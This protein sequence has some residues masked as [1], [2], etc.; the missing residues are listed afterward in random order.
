MGSK[1]KTPSAESHL[2]TPTRLTGAEIVWATLVGEGVSTVFGYPGGAILPVYDALR[3]FPI[4]HVLVRHEQGAAHM[5]DGYSRASGKVGVA[6]ATSGPGAT[7]LVTGIAT[8][9]LDSIPMV[10]ITGNVSSKV[11]GTDAFQ[12]VDITGITLPVTKHNFLVNK[13]EDVAHAIRYAFQIAQSGRPG[14]VL[15]DITKD[16][17]QGTA[18]FDFEAAKP[19]PYRPHPMLRVEENGLKH[20]AELIKNAKRPVI[21]AGHGVSESGAMEQ[22]QTLAERAQ[23]P[24]A[25]TLLG[26]GNFPA[27]HPLNLGM[28]GMHGESWVNTAIQEA[29]LLIACGMRFDDRVTGTLSTYAQ[30]AKKIHIEVDPAEVNKNVKVD[31]ALVGDLRSVLEDLLPRIAGRDGSAWLKTIESSKGAVS[32][33]DI[34]NLPDSGHLY[35]AHVM[36]DLWRITGGDAIVATDVGQHQMWEA[37]Y[38]HHEKPRSLVTSGGLGT[39]G[40]ALPAAIGAKMACPDKEVWVIAGDGGFQMT[41]AELS[42]IVQEKIKINIAIINNGYLGMVRQWQEFFYESNYEATPLV[43][44]DF[45]KLADAHGIAGRAVKTRTELAEAVNEA[46]SAPGA[47]LLNFL[48]EKEDSVY[49]MI[50]AGSALHEMIR[51]PGK[52]P[53]VESAD[54]E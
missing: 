32:V 46:R 42:T 9:M 7:N 38:F 24:V 5:A 18:I 12:E 40:F 1:A 21:L 45:V 22:V 37:Q 39:M 2:T 11:L 3:K 28:M 8:A 4:H 36:H 31:V 20:A 47:F 14:P 27:S 49:P 48:V 44:P 34:K 50:P 6:M 30:K 16:A 23:I 52:N 43:S 26:L 10:C 29:D 13:A 15:V 51:R 33:R 19:R 17:Q 25:L 35:A 41:A 53:L 54:D